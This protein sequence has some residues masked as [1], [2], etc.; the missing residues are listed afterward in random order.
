MSGNR[1]RAI[2]ETDN[3][4][5]YPLI[6]RLYNLFIVGVVSLFTWFFGAIVVVE[7]YKIIT[8]TSIYDASV[9]WV[10]S[11]SMIIGLIYF[12][13]GIS[14]VARVYGSG[15]IVSGLKKPFEL[16]AMSYRIARGT[17]LTDEDA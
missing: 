6:E 1:D 5:P 2:A 15:R 11:G 12:L 17:E 8:G 9:V 13:W 16:L 10:T 7:V 3:L 14:I 4:H